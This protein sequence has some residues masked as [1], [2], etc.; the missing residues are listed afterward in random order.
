MVKRCVGE[1]GDISGIHQVVLFKHFCAYSRDV[2]RFMGR[3]KGIADR[4]GG[5]V[6]LFQL[7]VSINF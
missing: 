5:N 6:P 4:T 3:D 1:S 7:K 2:A